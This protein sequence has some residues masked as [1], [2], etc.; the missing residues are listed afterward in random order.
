LRL[1]ETGGFQPQ[2]TTSKFV[3]KIWTWICILVSHWLGFLS[4]SQAFGFF[5][6]EPLAHFAC[7]FLLFANHLVFIRLRDW[8]KASR[9]IDYLLNFSNFFWI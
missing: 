6:F 4:F 8:N 3:W 9:G 7:D 1:K 2:Q 5:L